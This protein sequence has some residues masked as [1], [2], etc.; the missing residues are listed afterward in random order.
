MRKK[1]I[2]KILLLTILVVGS[3]FSASSPSRNLINESLNKG[4]NEQHYQDWQE[5]KLLIPNFQ[6]DKHGEENGNINEFKIYIYSAYYDWRIDRVRINSLIPL[7][8]D[9]RIEMECAV[10][11]DE[12]IYLG[13]IV[14]TIHKEHHNKEYVSSTLLCEVLDNEINFDEISGEILLRIFENGNIIN[15]SEK[16]III[17]S[18][19]KN[20]LNNYEL[21]ICVRPWWGEPIKNEDFGNQQK[22]NNAGLILEFINSYLYLGVNKFYL[23]QNYLE[24]DED[25]K[26]VINYY[27]N[28]KK[29]LE[30][31]P[32]ALPIIPF[33]QVWDFAQTTM[34]QD[35]LLRNIGET[36]YLL[37]VDT[38]EFVFPSLKNYNLIDFLNL[39]ESS[40]TYNKVGALWIPMYFHFLEWESDKNNLKRYSK[41][42]KEISEKMENLEFILYRKTCRMLS[43]GTK[44]SDK[45]RR[46]VII[47]P[48][49]VLYMGIHETEEMISKKFHFIKAPLISVGGKDELRIY[50]HHYRKAK[51]IVNNDPK[52]REL[53]DMYSENV[54]S[55]QLLDESTYSIG[56]SAIVDNI[57]WEIFGTDLYEIIFED[58]KEI[59]NIYKKKEMVKDNK[60]DDREKLH[61]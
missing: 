29:V 52:Q 6:I 2:L 34:I 41:I 36:K 18:I 49:R 30:I 1:F 4:R 20:S 8:F 3:S 28:I 22:F 12:N 35:C 26:N 43:S 25:V 11:K 46:K 31:I 13:T 48:E 32:Y 57:V 17:N 59:Q 51:G 24:L 7:N 16:W 10:M 42:E 21:N 44:K 38:D 9:N 15:K 61:D 39:M 19:P 27:S 56:N 58:V 50:L 14:K 23:Y 60:N 47:K 5:L 33:K 37:F 53:F 55:S 45:T 40:S 54:C